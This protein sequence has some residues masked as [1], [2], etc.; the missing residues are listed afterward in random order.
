MN[1]SQI[2]DY[3]NIIQISDQLVGDYILGNDKIEPE[4][5]DRFSDLAQMI[6]G[7]HVAIGQLGEAHPKHGE[8]TNWVN[9]WREIAVEI[10]SGITPSV[11]D[12]SSS[13]VKLS[14]SEQKN[15][16]SHQRTM[17]GALEQLEPFGAV[18]LVKFVGELVDGDKPTPEFLEA[19]TS[20][21][22]H[23]TDAV[24]KLFATHV[25]IWRGANLE[26]EKITRKLVAAKAVDYFRPSEPEHLINSIVTP[27][28]KIPSLGAMVGLLRGLSDKIKASQEENSGDVAVTLMKIETLIIASE[29]LFNAAGSSQM[30]KAE[31]IIEDSRMTPEGLVLKKIQ[32]HS[33]KIQEGYKNGLHGIDRIGDEE[34]G[35]KYVFA[36]NCKIKPIELTGDD[37][38]L[39]RN[40]KDPLFLAFIKQAQKELWLTIKADKDFID[41]AE[42]IDLY[43]KEMAAIEARILSGT[44]S[45]T[46]TKTYIALQRRCDALKNASKTAKADG[47]SPTTVR[48][49]FFDN[50][51]GC[52]LPTGASTSVILRKNK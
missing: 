18:D 25:T 39:A 27:E 41:I 6:S 43:S 35:F 30:K 26:A 37:A 48:S 38:R 33:V 1:S 15:L 20:L 9:E 52:S 7:W 28:G 34:S 19:S 32:N 10:E 4:R 16:A 42:T 11:P 3:T 47:S 21:Y 36:S 45:N 29:P 5:A 24:A 23:T 12:G 14:E 22:P 2:S 49:N 40:T 31:K 51:P 8:F 50:Q 44:M 17:S 46:D 13:E